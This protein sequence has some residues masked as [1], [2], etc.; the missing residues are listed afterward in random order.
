M[1]QYY[2]KGVGMVQQDFIFEGEKVSSSL[3]SYHLVK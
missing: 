1:Y 2:A 3:K